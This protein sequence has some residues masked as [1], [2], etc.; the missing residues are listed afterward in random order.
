MMVIGVTG[1]IG[2]GK[3]ELLS[4]IN[5]HYRCH[6]ILADDVANRVKEKGTA[7]YDAIVDLLG[8]SVL[9]PD[10]E[11]NRNKMAARIFADKKLLA[12]VNDILHPA[13]NTFIRDAIEEEKEKG[14]K[15]FLFIEAALL[16][17]SGY[18]HIVNRMWYIYAS[19]EVRRQRLK[20]GRGYSDEKITRI[21]EKQLSDEQFR[22]HSDIVIDN[23]GSLSDAYLQ[24]DRELEGYI[25][26]ES[27]TK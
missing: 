7:C 6:I 8:D 26:G 15:D 24:I 5:E 21:F 23:S 17:E 9:Q 18:E 25:G 27:G 14:E 13:V 2:A 20:A 16:I 19:E 12:K 11:I 10:G 3:S 4:Y 1:G 22:I